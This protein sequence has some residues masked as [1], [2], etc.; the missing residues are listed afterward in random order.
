M[1]FVMLIKKIPFNISIRTLHWESTMAIN[2]ITSIETFRVAFHNYFCLQFSSYGGIY[3]QCNEFSASK[4]CDVCL[5]HSFSHMHQRERERRSTRKH[6]VVG[7]DLDVYI[8]YAI[9]MARSF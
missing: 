2:S 8:I 6:S 4:L 7:C 1:Q 9:V 3:F 5:L